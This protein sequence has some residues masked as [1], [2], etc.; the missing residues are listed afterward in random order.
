MA[1]KIP[2]KI[3]TVHQRTCSEAVADIHLVGVGSSDDR[4][5]S[6]DQDDK[7]HA[8]R[9]ECQRL[10]GGPARAPI[11]PVLHRST[12]NTGAMRDRQSTEKP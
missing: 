1:V 2:A 12:N 5:R 11:K 4:Y 9:E 10:D 8:H 6:H 7:K 3:K